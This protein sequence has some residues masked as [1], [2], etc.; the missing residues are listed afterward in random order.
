M[1][2]K[3]GKITYNVHERGRG[4]SIGKDRRFDLRALA[5]LVN[6]EEV[7]ERVTNRDLKGFYGHV[8]RMKYGIQPPEMV[9]EDGKTIYIDPAVVT[10]HLSADDDGNITH[11]T[12][13]LDTAAGE[14]AE[15]L[16][17]SRQGGFSSAIFAKPRGPVDVPLV[18]AGFDYVFEP[19]YTTNRG[20]LLDSTGG[21]F[22]G[23]ML[24]AVMA[25]WTAGTAAMKA[26]YDSIERDHTLA[27]QTMDRL[28]EENEELMSLLAARGTANAAGVIVLDSTGGEQVRPM[29]VSKRATSQFARNANAFQNAALVGFDKLPDDKPDAPDDATLAAAKQRYGV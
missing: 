15:R 8:V 24:D 3:T 23:M 22:D 2:K 4:K 29:I 17:N 11:E 21:G 26:M 13:F 10:T 19:N 25:D 9:V 6:G 14:M 16:H 5:T 28:R 7:Q 18:F 20:Y 27:M 12:E 1:G